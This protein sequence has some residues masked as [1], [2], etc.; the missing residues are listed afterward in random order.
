MSIIMFVCA[1]S[2][3]QRCDDKPQSA[4]QQYFEEKWKIRNLLE[5]RERLQVP[6]HIFFSRQIQYKML[7][8]ITVHPS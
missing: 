5:R 4:Q 1:S 8:L 2:T 6:M 7:L 3:Y